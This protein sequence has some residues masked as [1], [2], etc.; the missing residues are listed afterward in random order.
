[1]PQLETIEKAEEPVAAKNTQPQPELETV[2][3]QQQHVEQQAPPIDKT[4]NSE[5]GPALPDNTF[6]RPPYYART[7][8]PYQEI[9][10]MQRQMKRAFN[11]A[12]GHYSHPGFRHHFR[13]DISAPKMDVREDNNQYT[14]FVNIPGADA[15]SLSVNLDDQRLSV[16]GRQSYEKQD[17][18][19]RGRIIFRERRSGK[20]Q[21]SITLPEPVKQKGMQTRIDNGVLTITIPKMK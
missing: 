19:E 12:Y 15:K 13:Q 7:W 9:E 20:F 2:P 11:N 1:V 14:V 18:D 8:D 21:R 16:R 10:R 3:D 4:V 17:R 6:S 5:N